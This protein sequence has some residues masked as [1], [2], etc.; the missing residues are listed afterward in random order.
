MRRNIGM[1]FQEFNLIE[2]L[3]VIDNVL[4]GRLGYTGTL[5]SLFRVFTADD[6]EQALRCSTAS[7]SASTS[8]SAPTASPAASA[9]AS[10]SR[11]R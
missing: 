2:R 4:T 6:I 10:A 3:S 11:A 9:S 5:R 1:I 7:A 8:T